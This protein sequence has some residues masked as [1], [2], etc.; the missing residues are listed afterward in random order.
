[1]FDQT[2]LKPYWS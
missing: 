2:E 1:M